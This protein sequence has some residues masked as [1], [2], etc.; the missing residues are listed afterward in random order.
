MKTKHI[1]LCILSTIAFFSCESFLEEDPKAVIAPETFFASENDARQAMNGVYGILKNNSIY[2]QVGLDVFYDNGADIIEPNRA[3][4]IFEPIGNYSLNE[5]IADV[6]VQ[7]MS[8]SDTWKDLYRVINNVNIVI[9]R[10]TD[11]NAITPASQTDI[12]ADARFVRALCYWHVTNLWGDA[13][14]Y[15]EAL[16]IDEVKVLGRTDE[17]TIINGILDDL[18]FAQANLQSTYVED[19]RGRASKWAAAIIE[20]KI[21]MQQ[22]EWQLGLDK[23]LEIINQSPHSLLPNYADVFDPKNEYNS[24]IIWSL[25]FAKDIRGQFEEG[26]VREDGTLPAVFGNGNWRP[27]MFSPRLR[28]EPKNSA[29]RGALADA[30]AARNEAFNGTGLQVASK[31]FAEKF[32]LN[33]LRRPLNIADTYLGFELNFP[34]M[35]KFWNLDVND[36]PRFNHSD[37]RLVF[38]LADVHLMAAECENERP[39]GNPSVAYGYIKE[40][41]ERAYETVAEAEAILGLSQQEFRQ[42]IYNERKWELAGECMRRYDLIR[43]GILL[44]VV[45]D[46]DY[47]FW[48]PAGNIKTWHVKLPIPLQELQTNPNLLES[49]PSNNGYR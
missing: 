34:Y 38:R 30:L 41:R 2:G 31:D 17:A 12:I 6:S 40:L 23:C 11:N 21:L 19:D 9:D 16:E 42:A 7:K 20:A 28:D 4:N 44:D 27:S 43:W 3:A 37:N 29:E 47:R 32:P 18:Q 10:V 35:P 49:D 36:S 8:V 48:D 26:T 1:F 22:K 33:D 24:E 39:G 13:P 15:T 5:A 46:L 25:D 45:Q 14:Y